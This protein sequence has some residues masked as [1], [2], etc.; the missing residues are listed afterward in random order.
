MF[1]T[2]EKFERFIGAEP[3]CERPCGEDVKKSL[4]AFLRTYCLLLVLMVVEFALLIAARSLLGAPVRLDRSQG[5]DT[6]ANLEWL[7]WHSLASLAVI[8]ALLAFRRAAHGLP[9]S[10]ILGPDLR[11]VRRCFAR[12]VFSAFLVYAPAS[13][14]LALWLGLSPSMDFSRWL[15]WLGPASLSLLAIAAKHELLLRGHALQRIGLVERH[16][17]FWAVCPSMIFAAA[18]FDPNLPLFCSALIFLSAFM[19]GMLSADLVAR[20]GN[21]GASLGFHFSSGFF[22]FSVI[23]LPGF[24]EYSVLILP[25]G[26]SDALALSGAIAA[27]AAAMLAAYLVCRR[28]TS[29]PGL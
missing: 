18:L 25:F 23:S 3:G 17:G 8:L 2:G 19:F 9:A 28:L 12:A 13:A 20:T 4:F 15:L 7:F 1:L 5:L 14:F 22:L 21:L 11:R 16:Y 26:A 24:L 29:G 10:S 6:E 27:G